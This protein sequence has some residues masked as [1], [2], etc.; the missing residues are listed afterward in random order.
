MKKVIIATLNED[1]NFAYK[2]LDDKDWCI[3]SNQFISKPFNEYDNQV[4]FS[5]EG[6]GG[7]Y[8]FDGAT[9][10]KKLKELSTSATIWYLTERLKETSEKA[11]KWDEYTAKLSNNLPNKNLS[12][13]QRSEAARKAVQARWAKK[14]KLNS[15]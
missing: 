6:M 8:L 15:L 5:E 14:N 11:R 4:V 13:E 3:E 7:L 9:L 12:A 2:V 1:N 10:S